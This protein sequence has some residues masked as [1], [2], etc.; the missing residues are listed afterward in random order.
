ML[1]MI[2]ESSQVDNTRHMSRRPSVQTMQTGV[3][4]GWYTMGMYGC[5][6]DLPLQFVKPPSGERNVNYRHV[7]SQIRIKSEKYLIACLYES[8]KH[9]F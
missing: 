6:I 9:P 8:L 1:V 4:A 5:G 7:Q 2:S 3:S